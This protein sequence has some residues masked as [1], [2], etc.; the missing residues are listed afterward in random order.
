MFKMISIIMV[1]SCLLLPSLV[2]IQAWE[3][4]Q[5]ESVVS[6]ERLFGSNPSE[7]PRGTYC[8]GLALFCCDTHRYVGWCVG[9][10]VCP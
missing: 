10:H 9:M 4:C 8:V 5:N 2:S 3:G 6:I 7:C 1:I